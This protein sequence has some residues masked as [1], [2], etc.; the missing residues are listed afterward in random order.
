MG[1]TAMLECF[2][3]VLFDIRANW[4][5]HLLTQPT[6]YGSIAY[7]YEKN[8]YPLALA[9]V[10]AQNS[11]A[12]AALIFL[13]QEDP[14]AAETLG[15]DFYSSFVLKGQMRKYFEF[16]DLLEPAYRDRMYAAMDWLTRT[17][18]LSRT[19]NPPRRFWRDAQ[20]DCTTL[21]DCRNTDNLRAMRETSVYLMAEET[22]NEATQQLYRSYL[23]RYV[24][25]L[26][27]IGMGEWD[28]PTYHGHTTAAYLNLYDFAQDPEVKEL[29][30]SGLDWLF[31]S[32][33]LKYWRGTWTAPAKRLGGEDAA[34]FFWLYFGEALPPDTVEK[35]WIHALA[36]DYQPPD[37]VL[38]LARR[39][40][41]K[42]LEIRRT[43][44]HY[45]NWKPEQ[46]GPAF[47]ET[48]YFGH[49]FQLGSLA[50]GTGGDWQGLGLHVMQGAE[51]DTLT[52]TG[53]GA[54][55]IAH[56][57]NLI[58][59][60]GETAPTITFPEG[61]VETVQG[62]TFVETEQTWLA[63]RPLAQG[64]VLE[65][66]EFPT[67]GTFDQFKTGVLARS[68]LTSTADTLEYQG[69]NGHTLALR[70]QDDNLPQVWRDGILHDWSQHTDMAVLQ[71]ALGGALWSSQDDGQRESFAP[72][73]ES[74]G[75]PFLE[76]STQA[77]SAGDRDTAPR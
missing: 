56:Y 9:D 18:P 2:L 4:A 24:S 43:H 40:F 32:A 11:Q 66:G 58:I 23:E 1:V 44:P 50:Q 55:H 34:R 35:D 17:D 29:A 19:A 5:L 57:R 41:P 68:R 59:W 53:G 28:S 39:E 10:W 65:V 46:Y 63:L 45:E 22:G 33:A 71:Q 67:H 52:V 12:E 15:I 42:P 37:A 7:E 38:R 48:L 36:T 26:L 13:Q 51:T 31:F 69:A 14:E 76:W 60:L 54:H 6:N 8:S 27:D 77:N 21:V 61:P 62:V 64:F 73:L 25:T 72:T 49:T 70:P 16:G 75:L 20:D 74:L 3:C 30:R 47:Y